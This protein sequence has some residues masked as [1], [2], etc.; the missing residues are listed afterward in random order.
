M[1]SFARAISATFRKGVLKKKNDSN[2]KM[3]E[4]YV[5]NSHTLR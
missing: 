1:E 2:E 5:G 4:L 3:K